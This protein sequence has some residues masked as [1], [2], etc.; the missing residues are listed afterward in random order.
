[1][2]GSVSC[3]GAG[4]WRLSQWRLLSLCD[5]RLAV[6]KVFMPSVLRPV[7]VSL[8]PIE[9]QDE[10]MKWPPRSAL[11]FRPGSESQCGTPAFPHAGCGACLCWSDMKRFHHHVGM[12]LLATCLYVA[13]GAAGSV[14][15][16]ALP[17]VP[18]QRAVEAFTRHAELNFADL[19]EGE[20][21]PVSDRI[22]DG[23]EAAPSLLV[24]PEG[25]S[26]RWGFKYQEASLQSVV[27]N[28]PSGELALLAA[29]DGVSRLTRR[30]RPPIDELASYR[31]A[32]KRSGMAPSVTIFVH[33]EGS[34][35]AYLP[36]LKRWLQANLMGFNVDCSKPGLADACTFAEQVAIPATA[37]VIAADGRLRRIEMPDV[38]ASSI[39][40]SWFVQ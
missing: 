3:D 30:S 21:T 25:S 29:V 32:V 16:T 1:M 17:K 39:S 9:Q 23:F 37:H 4:F 12:A 6:L 27:I 24:T 20:K 34:L 5:K 7:G 31:E 14:T 13:A 33:D 40:L 36:L 19:G 18:D 38:K 28:A 10:M 35:R 2:P 11:R 8:H 22:L 15:A 26:I